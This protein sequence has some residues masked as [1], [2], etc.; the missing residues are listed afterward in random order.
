[1]TRLHAMNEAGR[2]LKS[3]QIPHYLETRFNAED[4]IT[5]LDDVDCIHLT[6]FLGNALREVQMSCTFYEKW[7]DIQ[8]FPDAGGAPLPIEEPARTEVIR[9]LNEV[10]SH[11]KF[12]CAFYLD[13][14]TCDIVCAG[15][16]QY[17]VF[18]RV[19]ELFVDMVIAIQA[20]FDDVGNEL[21]DVIEGRLAAAEAFQ[22]VL[23]KG[24]KRAL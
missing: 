3:E 10:N 6:W 13:T 15:R 18:E 9:F 19:P 2:L 8:G 7:V 5:L 14:E 16:I 11:A 21:M 23:E 22:L 4:G 1:M 12:G 20:F 24:W 17:T